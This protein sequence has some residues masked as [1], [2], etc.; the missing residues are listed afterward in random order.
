MMD[1]EASSKLNLA[2]IT[3]ELEEFLLCPHVSSR[4]A[5]MRFMLVLLTKMIILYS[6]WSLR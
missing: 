5:K 3:V 2:Y 4:Q 6:N 1:Y